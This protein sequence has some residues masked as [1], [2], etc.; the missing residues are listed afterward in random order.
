MLC[1]REKSKWY[2]LTNITKFVDVFHLVVIPILETVF[3]L[4]TYLDSPVYTLLSEALSH[5]VQYQQRGNANQ[6]VTTHISR[7]KIIRLL[8]LPSPIFSSSLFIIKKGNFYKF[9]A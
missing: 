4:S 5:I 9:L 1:R 8:F 6:M 3:Q 7:L 2:Y